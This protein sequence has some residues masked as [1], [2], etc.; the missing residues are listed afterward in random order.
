VRRI[1]HERVD[2]TNL[3]VRRVWAGEPVVVVAAEQTAG[4]GRLGRSWLSPRGGV[5]LSV[6]WPLKLPFGAYQ[7]I[8]LA[9]GLATVE[10]IEETCGLRARIK[11]PNDVI[12]RERKLAGILCQAELDLPSASPGRAEQGA[13][14]AGVG[15]NGN[16]PASIL[17]AG[18]RHEPTSL[19]DEL[20]REV[21]LALLEESLV[22]RLE[23][24]FEA[25]ERGGWKSALLPAIRERLCWVGERIASSDTHG[26]P[27]AEGVMRGIDDSGALLVE[28]DREV[29][30]LA[31][32][33]IHR[34]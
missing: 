34:L 16:F 28:T 13:I 11:W 30:A 19:L 26:T 2:S 25:Y 9:V 24:A 14:V 32:G 7:A 8:P 5:W 18:L 21:D 27:I 15:V 22:R 10:A 31:I 29:R 33:E 1:V 17:G 3:E 4:M 23:E 6:G 20:G 12:A